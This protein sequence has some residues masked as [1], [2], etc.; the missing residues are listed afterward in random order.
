MNK[1]IVVAQ[2]YSVRDE[3][4]RDFLSALK[5]IK[6]IGYD[7]VELAG[8]YHYSAAEVKEMLSE[9][10]LTPVSAHV[11]LE[12][13]IKDPEK[14]A[15]T[16]KQIGC[17]YVAIPYL[18]DDRRPGAPMFAET[19][20]LIRKIGRLC[21]ERGMGLLY[22]NHDF[23]FITLPSGRYGLDELYTAVPPEL[24]RYSSNTAPS[25]G[26]AGYSWSTLVTSM[27]AA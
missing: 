8:L 14:T 1:L 27:L 18:N 16:Y 6:N 4:E 7:A 11:A 25:T 23:E 15:D 24:L 22:H 9:A 2:I 12:E 10:G 26:T 13:W 5:E 3:A 20:D 17:A 21:N 19:V